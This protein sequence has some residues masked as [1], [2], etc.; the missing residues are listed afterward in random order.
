MPTVLLCTL[1]AGE[2][3]NGLNLGKPP[4]PHNA[5]KINK[6]AVTGAKGKKD[7]VQLPPSDP[8]LASNHSPPNNASMP[9]HTASVPPYSASFPPRAYPHPPFSWGGRKPCLGEAACG[10]SP[11][12]PGDHSA[13]ADTLLP[14]GEAKGR[15]PLLPGQETLHTLHLEETLEN[16]GNLQTLECGWEGGK[17]GLGAR[18]ARDVPLELFDAVEEEGGTVRDRLFHSELAGGTAVGARSR[19]F[20]PDGRWEWQPC[21]ITSYDRYFYFFGTFVFI[22]FPLF[23]FSAFLSFL[24]SLPLGAGG[25]VEG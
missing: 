21:T 24:L 20:Y 7:F 12:P 11:A 2:N 10:G 3:S 15:A 13:A 6:P 19:Y 4:P 22:T 9:E 18:H 8:T 17:L 5:P 25:R 14:E 23:I 1:L 16:P